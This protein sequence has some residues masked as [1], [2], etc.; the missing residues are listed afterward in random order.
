[1]KTPCHVIIELTAK[2]W[3]VTVG[4]ILCRRRGVATEA[5]LAAYLAVYEM[6]RDLSTIVIG[7]VFRGRDHS[8]IILGV[9]KAR[10][11][12]ANSEDFQIKVDA[13]KEKAC[14]WRPPEKMV[15]FSYEGRAPNG[16]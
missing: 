11:V 4:E 5:R 13:V 14:Q 6:R 10:A 15:I 7:R 16:L 1:M 2:E 8:T 9:H 12:A 3:G